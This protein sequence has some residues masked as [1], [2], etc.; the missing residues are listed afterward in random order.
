MRKHDK[1]LQQPCIGLLH[2]RI[3]LHLLTGL[4]RVSTCEIVGILSCGPIMNRANFESEVDMSRHFYATTRLPSSLTTSY[5][6]LA[7][8]PL[9]RVIFFLQ[10]I[11]YTTAVRHPKQLCEMGFSFINKIEKMK[12]ALNHKRAK[13]LYIVYNVIDGYCSRDKH[14]VKHNLTLCKTFDDLIFA[15]KVN[16]MCGS[17][18]R[19]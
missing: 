9:N 19:R 4:P 16:D 15:S 17:F 14:N 7:T 3:N 5:R 11:V 13:T 1:I 18:Q 10:N 8:A 2:G 12:C 6:G